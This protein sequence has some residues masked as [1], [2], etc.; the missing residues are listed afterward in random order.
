MPFRRQ[1]ASRIGFLT[2][3]FI[4]RR[5]LDHIAESSCIDS[6]PSHDKCHPA[7]QQHEN[8][9][10]LTSSQAMLLEQTHQ[11]LPQDYKSHSQRKV[12][13]H[14]LCKHKQVDGIYVSAFSTFKRRTDGPLIAILKLSYDHPAAILRLSDAHPTAFLRHGNGH[15][16]AI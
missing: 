9:N 5:I 11:K 15:L 8:Y 13:S 1:A 4:F 16:T 10:H 2:F 12:V 3:F 6:I 7:Q 14:R